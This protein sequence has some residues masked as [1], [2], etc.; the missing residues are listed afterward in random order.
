MTKHG[1]EILGMVSPLF[2]TTQNVKDKLIEEFLTS[3]V[4]NLM[5][6]IKDVDFSFAESTYFLVEA[7]KPLNSAEDAFGITIIPI[8]LKKML[9]NGYN[10]K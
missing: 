9:K 5:A 4:E 2:A 1:K 7:K 8:P 10:G 6:E 3:V